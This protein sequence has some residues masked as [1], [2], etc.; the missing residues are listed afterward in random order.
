MR[1][2][3]G[4]VALLRTAPITLRLPA[5]YRADNR[6]GFYLNAFVAVTSAGVPPKR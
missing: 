6:R 4:A 1:P 3:P 2:E 5:G